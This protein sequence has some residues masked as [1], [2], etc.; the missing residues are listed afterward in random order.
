M[1]AATQEGAWLTGYRRDP[2]PL[3]RVV[4]PL[5]G[6]EATL[7]VDELALRQ[8]LP[9]DLGETIPGYMFSCV[10]LVGGG[11]PSRLTVSQQPLVRRF[12]VE[13]RP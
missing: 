3:A 9:A 7:D 8:E 11:C 1:R 12:P 13:A 5:A 2:V 4:V 10:L 6:L